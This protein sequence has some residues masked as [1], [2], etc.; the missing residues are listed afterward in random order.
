MGIGQA[1]LG[2][3]LISMPPKPT[4]K[5]PGPRWPSRGIRR[6][7][8]D[9]AR[10]HPYHRPVR[11]HRHPPHGQHGRSG[12]GRRRQ[13]PRA[14]S[15]RS[16]RSTPFASSVTSPS[17]HTG[18]RQGRGQGG[19]ED[20]RPR[21]PHRDRRPSRARHRARPTDT[22]HARGDRPQKPRRI[23]PPRHVRAGDATT[24]PRPRRTSPESDPGKKEGSWQRYIAPHACA[25]G[26]CSHR[27]HF[28][29][30]AAPPL[31]HVSQAHPS[32][33][34]GNPARSRST[35][36]PPTS[37]RCTASFSPS[38]CPPCCTSRTRK[39]STSS[40]PACRSWASGAAT[41]ATSKPF[42]PSSRLPSPTSTS[43]ASTRTPTVPSPPPTSPT[44]SP[45]SPSSGSSTPARVVYDI[46]ASRRRM[47]AS[48]LQ[49]D[50]VTLDTSRLAAVQYYDLVLARARLAVAPSPSPK[51]RSS[52]GSPRLK[53]DSGT[54]L[55]TDA[56]RPGQPRRLPAGRR[57][58]ASTSSTRPR[59]PSRSRYTST[60]SSPSCPKTNRSSRPRW[61]ATTC[62]SRSCSPWPPNTAPT[63]K[64]SAL[65]S[66]PSKRTP[67]P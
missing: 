34:A 62:R 42:S 1:K 49:Q 31:G 39:T 18:R 27:S 10:L 21:Q 67:A 25:A 11:R 24:S 28:R 64:P 41:K 44:S 7:R 47:E 60:R 54:G 8:G 33:A 37:S 13:P 35:S 16:S 58:R 19:S 15:S 56:L 20:L 66:S 38:T 45:P 61:C 59:S 53:V 4:A 51:P 2:A 9:D 14:A 57:A 6:R 22:H 30:S 29:S 65:C 48:E 12:P 17:S 3:G 5:S 36:A 40:R 43:K 52:C 32:V 26:R 63:C 50:A 23:A 55:P 46:I